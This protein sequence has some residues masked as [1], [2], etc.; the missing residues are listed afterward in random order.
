MLMVFIISAYFPLMFFLP[1]LIS[2]VFFS[3]IIS[4]SYLRS[5]LSLSTLRVVK[6]ILLV[7][8]L[9]LHFSLYGV[10]IFGS[11]A[12]VSLLALMTSVKWWE[13]R[14]IRDQRVLLFLGNF[15]AASSALFSQSLWLGLYLLGYLCFFFLMLRRDHLLSLGH[16]FQSSL[17]S[18]GEVRSIMGLFL[19]ALPLSIILFLLFPRLPG[20]IVGVREEHR[21]LSG[22]SSIM[23]PGEVSSLVRSNRVA[24]RVRF[25][26]KFSSQVAGLYWRCVVFSHYG[27]GVWTMAHEDMGQKYPSPLS[28][29]VLWPGKVVGYYLYLLPGGS[30]FLPLLEMGQIYAFP[31]GIEPHLH[32]GLFYTTDH[33]IGTPIAYKGRW[34]SRY[35]FRGGVGEKKV[36][37]ETG[38]EGENPHS[39]TLVIS[40]RKGGA[41]DWDV[42]ER[43]LHFFAT[44]GFVYTL[45]P[46]LWPPKNGLDFFLFT[47]KRGFCEH[48]AM[49]TAL[50]LRY[51][52]IPARVVAG[53]K[54]GEINPMGDYVIVRDRDAHAWVEAYLGD[55]G[56]VRID[57]TAYLSH[58]EV[59]RELA[60]EVERGPYL[61]LPSGVV[62]PFLLFWDYLNYQWLVWMV[63]YDQEQQLSLLHR[64]GLGGEYT[65]L[66]QNSILV[67]LGSLLLT[68][69]CVFLSLN[70][71]GRRDSE[72]LRYYSIF[73]KKLEKR[74]L[75]ILPSQGPWEVREMVRDE[76]GEE[77]EKVDRIISLFVEIVFAGRGGVKEIRELRERIK[78][79]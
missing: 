58:T 78:D 8:C 10:T 44:Q 14:E 77:F 17:F 20:A 39:H 38:R 25:E 75:K 76:I 16:G 35:V 5:L 49:A 33:L 67:I 69:G 45:N 61:Y 12:G 2:L 59:A 64:L 4:Y 71:K 19:L 63:S 34:Y 6:F 26:H 15:L 28:S 60:G 62:R 68:L 40:F 54:G 72:V 30:K 24:F 41:S 52:S 42:V 31:P 18:P 3:L 48:Y 1:S 74:G 23:R 66:M 47:S 70:R 13:L 79:F 27:N 21:A 37:L 55:R 36:F 9:I 43:V 11:Y 7:L 46:P 29:L 32:E 50:L 57:P 56:W 51:A 53:Y 22:L 73:L 65:H